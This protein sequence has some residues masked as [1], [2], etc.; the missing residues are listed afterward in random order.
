MLSTVLLLAIWGVAI[1]P[2]ATVLTSVSFVLGAFWPRLANGLKLAGLVG[3]LVL[4]FMVDAWDRGTTW[5]T[6]WN[7]TSYGIVRVNLDSLVA[8]YQTAVLGVPDPSQHAALAL[9]LQQAP[10]SLTPWIAPHAV[11]VLLSLTLV[12]ATAL[13]FSRFRP[14]VAQS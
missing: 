4:V 12:A 7:P 10:V 5:F 8:Q 11:L 6:Y 2:A 3:W 13:L 9:K 14:V 1:I